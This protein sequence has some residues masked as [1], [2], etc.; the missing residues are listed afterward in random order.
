MIG[1]VQPILVE[2]P[3]TGHTDNFAPVAIAGGTRGQSGIARI[4]GSDGN[5]LVAV[6]A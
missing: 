1:S 5:Q 4:I 2:G 6:W 3:G